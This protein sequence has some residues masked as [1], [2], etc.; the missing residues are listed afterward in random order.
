MDWFYFSLF[1]TVYAFGQHTIDYYNGLRVTEV[2]YNPPEPT[3]T[4][5]GAG[6]SDHT[7]FTYAEFT[8]VDRI[9]IDLKDID[10]EGLGTI[11]WGN[12]GR[13]SFSGSTLS[14]GDYGLFVADIGAFE[15]RYAETMIKPAFIVQF[16]GKLSQKGEKI[17]LKVEVQSSSDPSQNQT[18]EILKFQYENNH[19][20][21]PALANGAGH[22]LVVKTVEKN[23]TS[24]S[25]WRPSLCI[26]GSPGGPDDSNSNCASTHIKCSNSDMT[27]MPCG[28]NGKCWLTMINNRE[29]PYC[30][31][32]PDWEDPNCGTKKQNLQGKSLWIILIVLLITVSVCAAICLYSKRFQK[33]AEREIQMEDD[34]AAYLPP[35]LRKSST[36]KNDGYG[37][38]AG[39]TG[40]LFGTA[41]QTLETLQ[42]YLLDDD[43]DVPY[44]DV[45]DKKEKWCTVCQ[46]N[47]HDDSECGF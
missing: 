36:L 26:G 21:W 34:G 24:Y 39:S 28:E 11:Q 3:F 10:F 37:R 15:Q 2:M 32:K 47:T 30:E 16:S 20:P 35:D 22:S 23:P 14:R 29:Q 41:G 25:S 5:Q 8:N 18:K 31:C 27:V 4:E 7:S 13:D 45:T 40:Q 9:P 38:M 33:K 19:P 17:S 43:K 1:F 6:Y 46:S 44:V 42:H 12:D